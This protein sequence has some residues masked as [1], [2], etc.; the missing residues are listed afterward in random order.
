MSMHIMYCEQWGISKDE[1]IN[2]PQTQASIAYSQFLCQKGETGDILDLYTAL[3][4]CYVGYTE[5]ALRLKKESQT[6]CSLE[7]NPYS[8][9]INT[10]AGDKFVQGS[11]SKVIML[12]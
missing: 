1:L 3:M 12:D 8:K 6:T 11:V 9:W 5:I 4:P 10:Y 2:E 7:N